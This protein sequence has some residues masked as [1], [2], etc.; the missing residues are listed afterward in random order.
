VEHVAVGSDFDGATTTPF[1]ATG[2]AQVTQA[3]STRGSRPRT[4]RG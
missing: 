3:C 4:S 2:L 1:D